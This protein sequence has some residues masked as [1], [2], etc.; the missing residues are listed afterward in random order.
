MTK[1]VFLLFPFFL[2]LTSCVS[3][4]EVQLTNVTIRDFNT[5]GGKMRATFDLEI[6]NPNALPI[7]ISK[8]RLK[9]FIGD[10][11]LKDW[12]VSKKIKLRRKS[13]QS[14]PFYIEVS[15]LQAMMVLP[16]LLTQPEISIDGTVK[17]GSFIFGKRIPL[18]IRESLY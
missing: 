4:S 3:F 16:R 10:L 1:I 17:A 18:Q 6:D 9:V 2:V 12:S 11:E 8:P 13:K 14:Y 15:A 7:R 5:D